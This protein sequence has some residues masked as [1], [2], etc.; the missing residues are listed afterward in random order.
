MTYLNT[1][2]FILPL[3][4]VLIK[5]AYCRPEEFR[6]FLRDFLASFRARKT[7]SVSQ[8]NPFTGPQYYADNPNTPEAQA[9]LIDDSQQLYDSAKSRS[10]RSG[11]LTSGRLSLGETARVSLEFCLLWFAANYFVGACLEYTTVA[12]STILTS[13]SSVFT[14]LFG[15]FFGVE[16]Y[17]VR[18]LL[19]VLASLAGI[20]MISSLD[21]NGSNNDEEHRGDFPEKTMHEIAIGDALA[22]LSAVLYGMYAVFFKYRVGDESRINMPLFFGFVGVSNVL[23]LWPGLLI[24]HFTGVER[25]ELP[26][27]SFIWLIV[28]FNSIASLLSDIAWAFAVLLTSPIVVTV[29]LSMSIPLS[30]VGEMVLNNQTVSVLYLVG[31]CIVLLSFVFVNH[32]EKVDGSEQLPARNDG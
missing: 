17:T 1:A 20:A 31:A 24:L 6:S 14:L 28:I 4:P 13:T 25:F 19:G 9:L 18:K 23:L 22:F 11:I 32:E 8:P 3:I 5:E 12:S 10:L 29:G 2:C 30:L 16:R 26:S 21:L 7:D 27:S 15:A